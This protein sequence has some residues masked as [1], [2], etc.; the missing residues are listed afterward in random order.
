MNRYRSLLLTAV[1]ATITAAAAEAATY[2]VSPAGN[3]GAPGTISSPLRTISHAATLARPGDVVEVRGGVYTE[4]VKI[5]SRGTASA[6][7]VFRSYRGEQAVIDGAGTAYNTDLVQLTGAEYVDLSGFEIRNSTRLGIA[8][9]GASNIRIIGNTVHGS[10]RG[11]IYFGHSSYGSTREIE[12]S[13]NRVF[14]NVLENQYHTMNGGWGQAVSAQ[15]AE[16]VSI[17]GNHVH[18]N[19]GEGIVVL[20][21]NDVLVQKNRVHDNFSVEI[22]LDN[23]RL[24]TVD[25]NHVYSTGNSRYHRNGHPAH[26]ISAAN[27][28]YSTSNPL[29]DIRITNN[30]VI[31]SRSGFFYGNYENGGGLK[32]VTIANN[33]FHGSTDA[34]LI[35]QADSHAGTSIRNNIFS[36]TGGAPL[37]SVAGGGVVYGHNNW[38]GG[39]AGAAGGAGD[40]VADPQ[41]ASAS[42]FETADY[43][44][45]PASPLVGAGAQIPEVASDHWLTARVL[46]NDIGAHQ[47][48]SL[49]GGGGATTPEP[50][51]APR[52]RKRGVGRR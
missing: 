22:Y 13:G 17:T 15:R 18:E 2:V 24:T 1:A 5:R 20:L 50:G 31:G 4:I 27:E 6:R 40:I 23:A 12:I 49:S 42:G 14:N 51:P 45:S 7:I 43:R 28:S 16:R 29:G 26:G 32:N 9:W 35:I 33:T 34:M 46:R 8:G 39:S 10:T 25:A 11:G 3:D 52:S 30:I 47:T 19:D 21:S 41:F 37:V 44:I 38:W 36:Q 48:A